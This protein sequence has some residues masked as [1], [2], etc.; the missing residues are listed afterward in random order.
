MDKHRS[1]CLLLTIFL[2]TV[3]DEALHNMEDQERKPTISEMLTS[4]FSFSTISTPSISYLEKAKTLAKQAHAYFFPPNLD[5]RS[6][7]EVQGNG[8]GGAGEKVREAVADSLGESKATV[9]DSAELV[10]KLV[11]ETVHKTVE[12]VKKSLS[13]RGGDTQAEL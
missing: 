10:A 6:S 9:E 11:T 12:K 2:L 3:G 7:D 8:G 1:F 13:E 5:F 4:M